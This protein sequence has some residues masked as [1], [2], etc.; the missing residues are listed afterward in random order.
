MDRGSR[1]FSNLAE[2]ALGFFL[3]VVTSLLNGIDSSGNW[4]LVRYARP[5]SPTE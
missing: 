4:D 1:R 2:N 5:F 3:F